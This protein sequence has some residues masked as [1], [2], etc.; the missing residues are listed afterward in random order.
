M[1]IWNQIETQDDMDAFKAY[2]DVCGEF[3]NSTLEVMRELR[4]SKY[5]LDPIE[6]HFKKELYL[7][8][9]LKF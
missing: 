6:D 5:I 4:G 8:S 1:S 9:L 3:Q 2:R 7:F